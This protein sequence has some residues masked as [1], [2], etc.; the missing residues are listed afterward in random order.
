MNYK[1]K[2]L[3]KRILDISYKNKLSHLGSYF[4]CIDIIDDIF[5][6]KKNDD[7]FILS[8]GHAALALYCVIEKYYGIDA[9]S[10]FLKHGGHPHL[11]EDNHIY[12]STGSLGMGITV[13]IGR[14]I[15][16][17]NKKVYC[18]ISD[19]ETAE[20]SIWE[21]LRF[22]KEKNIKNIEIHCSCNG[23]AAYD[24]IDKEYLKQ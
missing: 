1:D 9:E 20:G 11:D 5:K 19:G 24:N 4:S 16:N 2:N 23:Y 17:P 8:C 7:I 6:N 13:A 18:L 14:A 15:A 3:I 22:I 10:L 21:A 12:C